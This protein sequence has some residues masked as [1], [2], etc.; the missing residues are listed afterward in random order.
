MATGLVLQNGRASDSFR[1]KYFSALTGSFQNKSN[2]DKNHRENNF[3]KFA[4]G[5][6]LHLGEP[7]DYGSIMHYGTHAFSS[8]GKPTITTLQTGG[9]QIGQREALSANDIRQIN[10]LYKCPTGRSFLS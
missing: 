6:I 4:Q 9:A 3:D 2:S 1:L 10:K 5:K 7:Y 8:N